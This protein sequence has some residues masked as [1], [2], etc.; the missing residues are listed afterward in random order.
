M[1]AELKTHPRSSAIHK[2]GQPITPSPGG[3]TDMP[4]RRAEVR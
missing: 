2:L 1:D 3:R 4:H